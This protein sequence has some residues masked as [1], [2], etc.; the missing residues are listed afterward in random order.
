MSQE[1]Q[2]D[3]ERVQ[4]CAFKIILRNKYI[5][6]EN[7]CQELNLQTLK[8]RREYLFEKFTLRNIQHEKFQMF[9][10]ENQNMM[11]LRNPL[12][13]KISYTNTERFKRS[14]ILEMQHKANDLHKK[15]KLK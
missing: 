10:Q 15:G 1:N 11:N 14:T 12:K 13:F 2:E 4:K 6:Y 7:A 5:N 8:E 3:I 9:F